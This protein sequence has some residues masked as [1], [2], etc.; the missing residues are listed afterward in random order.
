MHRV[1]QLQR[2]GRC[3]TTSTALGALLVRLGRGNRELPTSEC[4]AVGDGNL[5]HGRDLRCMQPENGGLLISQHLL[6]VRAHD[7]EA[8]VRRLVDQLHLVRREIAVLAKVFEAQR[9]WKVDRLEGGEAMLKA[10]LRRAVLGDH[11]LNKA[12]AF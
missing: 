2:H 4:D 9:R 8:F 1:I 7:L 10:G 11:R 12:F 6:A 3:S 5:D